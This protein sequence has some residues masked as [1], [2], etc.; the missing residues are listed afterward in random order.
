M[1][2]R[3]LEILQHSIGVDKYGQGERNR[4]YFCAGSDDEPVCRELVAMGY[5]ETFTRSFLPYYNCRVTE[6]GK[7]AML[8]ESPA[9]PNLTQGQKRY[10]KFLKADTG[11]S[12]GR[13]LKDQSGLRGAATHD[14]G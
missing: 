1:T 12:F 8:A 6:A 2:E 11:E 10:R 7:L 5:M 9:T 3:Q 13:W 14:A 4:N